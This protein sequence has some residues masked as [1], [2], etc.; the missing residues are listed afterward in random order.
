MPS[1]TYQARKKPTQVRARATYDA[2][3]EAAAQLLDRQGYAGVSTNSIAERAG[4]SIGSVYEYFA[5]KEAIFAALKAR[6]DRETLASVLNELADVD[7]KDPDAFL[8]AVLEARVRAALDQPRLEALLHD[9]IPASVFAAQSEV[10]MQAFDSA[11]RAFVD[12]N[13][14]LIRVQDLDVSIK[15]GTAVVELSVRHFAANEPELLAAPAMID[16]LS[17][18][19][20]R[21]ILKDPSERTTK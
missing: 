21:W 9:E 4:V 16:A 1:K 19:M 3:L 17:D 6:L 18:M 7:G 2:I 15:L 20:I 10:S 12:R 5:S 11:M 8:R 13:P 14:G